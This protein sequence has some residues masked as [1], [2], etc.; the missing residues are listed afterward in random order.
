[1]P[2]SLSRVHTDV[3]SGLDISS[4]GMETVLITTHALISHKVPGTRCPT[5]AQAGKEV[6]VIP[7]R[8]CGYCGTPCVD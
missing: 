8:C 3:E 2:S 1:M 5:C 4:Y 7:G 6:W